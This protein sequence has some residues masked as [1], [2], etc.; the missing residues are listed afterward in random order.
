MIY[1][2]KYWGPKVW[3]L[4]HIFSMNNNLK[5]LNNK[6]HNYYIFYTSFY[7]IL[8]CFICSKHYHEILYYINPLEEDKINQKYL[9]KWVYD[10]HNIVNDI[11][12]KPLYKYSTLK[13]EYKTVDHNKLFFT[14]KILFNNLNF[15][16]MS[17]IMYDQVYNFFI[18]FCILYPNKNIKKTLKKIIHSN[19]FLNNDTPKKFKKWLDHFFL[20]IGIYIKY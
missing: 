8:P 2:K 5:I 7:Y 4:L 3:Y 20:D 1:G 16:N 11:L 17:L 18:N 10:T 12:N 14:L 15:E 9:K 19:K 6:I 13:K